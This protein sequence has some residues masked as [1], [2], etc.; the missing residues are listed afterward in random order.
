MTGF[1]VNKVVGNKVYPN[2]MDGIKSGLVL[3]RNFNANFEK[4]LE[5]SKTVRK[6]AVSFK[7]SAGNI[8]ATDEDDNTVSIKLPIG[9][10]PKNIEKL[11]ENYI[12]QLK[13]TGTSDFYTTSVDIEDDDLSF[14]PVAKLT[15]REENC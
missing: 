2:K 9:E 3:Y 7:I 15:K 11:K 6:I 10:T 12:N 8:V 14:V 4:L 13:K 5:N 1:L